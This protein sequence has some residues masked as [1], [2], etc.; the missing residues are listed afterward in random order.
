MS[1]ESQSCFIVRRIAECT[2]RSGQRKPCVSTVAEQHTKEL[3][4]S[5]SEEL[6]A[7]VAPV[8]M[9]NSPAK[10]GLLDRVIMCM[11]CL[12]KRVACVS[13]LSS[14]TICYKSIHT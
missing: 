12:D 9:K 2:T 14:T 4:K 10:E 13:Y 1:K 7:Y 6:D 8:M 5:S 3:S 11:R